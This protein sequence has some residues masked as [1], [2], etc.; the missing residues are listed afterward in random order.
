MLFLQHTQEQFC[1]V[2][3]THNAKQR[4]IGTERSGI[5]RHIACTTNAVFFFLQ[6]HNRYRCFGRY[7]VCGSP[8]I[9]I[10]HYIANY[11]YAQVFH[12]GKQLFK[13]RDG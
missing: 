4:G 11:S 6:R 2:I 12:I 13:I 5:E 10:Q 7:T 8:P 3:C 9:S 1:I